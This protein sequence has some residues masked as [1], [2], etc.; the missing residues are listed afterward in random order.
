MKNPSIAAAVGTTAARPEPTSILRR[1]N[2]LVPNV[3]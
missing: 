1:L 3:I 2:R